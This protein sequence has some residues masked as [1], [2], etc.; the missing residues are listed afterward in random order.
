MKVGDLLRLHANE[1]NGCLV[2]H[3]QQLQ[4]HAANAGRGATMVKQKIREAASSK[5]SWIL[6]L[7]CVSYP[8]AN[9]AKRCPAS[10]IAMTNETKQT[11]QAR[12]MTI[13][14]KRTSKTN[15]K[16]SIDAEPHPITGMVQGN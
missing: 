14:M 3:A 10:P 13:H 1:Y 9:V 5:A 4:K 6:R 8:Q 11:Q 16:S 15:Q 2:H 12:N 7:R